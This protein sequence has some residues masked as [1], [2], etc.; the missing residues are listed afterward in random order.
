MPR[1]IGCK[2]DPKN[3]KTIFIVFGCKESMANCK[4]LREYFNLSRKEFANLTCIPVRTIETW[5][6]KDSMPEYVLLA[7]MRWLESTLQVADKYRDSVGVK[8]TIVRDMAKNEGEAKSF[9]R[10]AFE[11]LFGEDYDEVQKGEAYNKQDANIYEYSSFYA[12][13][14]F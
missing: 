10:D 4:Y 9:L 12:H 5:E 14:V 11:N 8:H 6:Q 13:G 2:D 7:I 1:A 3:A